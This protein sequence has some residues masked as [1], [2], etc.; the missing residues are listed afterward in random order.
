[1]RA[2]IAPTGI[3]PCGDCATVSG[4][5]GIS[6]EST[7]SKVIVLSPLEQPVQPVRVSKIYREVP[8]EVQGAV[9][10]VDLMELPFGDFDLILGINWLVKQ[11]VILGYVTKRVILRTED[12][13]VVVVIEKLV[14]KGCEAYLA[15]VNV[16]V[17]KD[18]FVRDIRTV[19]DFL[20]AF[21]EELPGLPPNREIEFGIELLPGTVPV[22]IATYRMAPKEFTEFKAQLQELL[23]L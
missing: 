15:Y 12:D 10:L 17:F 13:N 16:F 23:H 20:N 5:L 7:T 8:L 19:R 18:S 11:R 3:Q 4:N 22:F 21:L 14:R 2:H 1:M 9:F 6:V